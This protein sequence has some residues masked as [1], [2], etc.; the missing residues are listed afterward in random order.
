[1]RRNVCSNFRSDISLTGRP[2]FGADA[3]TAG[4]LVCAPMRAGLEVRFTRWAFVPA[5]VDLHEDPHAG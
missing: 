2:P 1:M 3:A 5:D 4:P